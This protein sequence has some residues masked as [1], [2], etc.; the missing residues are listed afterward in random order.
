MKVIQRLIRGARYSEKY[1]HHPGT[2]IMIAFLAMGAV[3][4]AK[5]GVYSAIGG[6]LIM[7]I[8]AVPMWLIG[9]WNR[10]E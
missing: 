1:G 3:A 7:A 2:E 9:C 5:G 6:F 8:F 4:G 10:S